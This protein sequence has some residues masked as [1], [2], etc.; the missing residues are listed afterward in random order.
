MA[1]PFTRFSFGFLEKGKPIFKDPF[2]LY[3]TIA[4][5]FSPSIFSL[6][7][8]LFIKVNSIPLVTSNSLK[9]TKSL[10][11]FVCAEVTTNKKKFILN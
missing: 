5:A 3:I 4:S 10:K 6:F 1:F 7:S 8:L 11:V 9:L 2:V